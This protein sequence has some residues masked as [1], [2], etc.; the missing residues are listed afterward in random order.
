MKELVGIAKDIHSIIEE[1]TRERQNISTVAQNKAKAIGDYDKAI[2]L[3]IVKLR[4]GI[5]F[6]FD[7]QTIQNPPVTIIEKIAKG[8]CSEKGVEADKQEALYRATLSNLATLQAQL[9]G[10]QSLL[11]YME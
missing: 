9:N 10:L 1:M 6:E 11:K 2:A 4:N 8:I 3:T 5:S 7:G